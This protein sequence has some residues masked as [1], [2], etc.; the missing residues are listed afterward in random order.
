MTSESTSGE[1][2]VLEF[3]EIRLDLQDEQ[4]WRG[5]RA[6]QLRP[7]TWQVLRHLVEQ[8]GKLVTTSQLL[9]A[10]WSDVDVSQGTLTQSIAELRRALED[11]AGQ[12]RFIQTVHRRGYRFIAAFRSSPSPEAPHGP[13][14]PCL[15]PS[16][17][18]GKKERDEG[19][20]PGREPEL[21]RLNLLMNEA[22]AGKRQIVFVSGEAGIGKTC[23]IRTFLKGLTHRKTEEPVWIT[24]GRCVEF[25]GEGETFLPVLEALEHLAQIVEPKRFRR[26]VRSRAPNWLAQIPWLAEPDEEQET[27][28]SVHFAT[29]KR[30]LRE[31]CVAVEALTAEGTL[32]LWIEDLHWSDYATVDLIAALASRTEPC[33]LLL[34]ATYRPVEAAMNSHPIAPL[35]RNLVQQQAGVEL[36]LRPLNK[37][38]IQSYLDRQFAPGFEPSLVDVIYDLT[39]GNPLFMVTLVNHLFDKGLLKQTDEQSPWTLIFPIEQL[40]DSPPESLGALIE[41]QLNRMDTESLSALEAGSVEGV[42][43]GAQAA[44]AAAGK[45]VE[46]VETTLGMLAG[47]GQFLKAVG[48]ERWPDGSVG[49]G[50]RFL[51]AA[52]S[53]ILYQR[54]TAARRQ[55]AHLRIAERL[56]EGFQ[57]QPDLPAAKLA[58]HFEKGGDPERAVHYLVRAA[59]GARAR[60]GDRETLKYFN[61]TFDQLA[62][63]PDTDERARLELDLRMKLARELNSAAGFSSAQQGL[64]LARALELCDRFGDGSTLGYIQSYQARSQITASDFEAVWSLRDQRLELAESLGDPVLLAAT[65]KE[66][67]EV[68]MQRADF[69]CARQEFE[70]CLEAVEGAEPPKHH[71]MHGHDSAVMSLGL[72]GWTAWEQGLPDEAQRKAEACLARADFVAYPFDRLLA[73]ILALAVAVLRRDVDVATPLAGA[74]ED[75]A[76]EY[77]FTLPQAVIPAALGWVMARNGNTAAAAEQMREGIAVSRSAGTVRFLSF[78]LVTLAQTELEHGGA[79]EGFEA[80]GEAL[81]H[82]EKTGDRIHEAEIHRLRGELLRLDGGD[83][84][85]GACF[86]QALEVARSQGARSLELRA[87]TSLSRFWRDESREDEARSLLAPVYDG[88]TEGFDTQDLRDAKA[89]LDSL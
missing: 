22:R 2:T 26:I 35:K 86:E 79:E 13:G 51:H 27:P 44:A 1:P 82:V 10:V 85:A 81:T 80:L 36:P 46:A 70:R 11:D 21:E 65:H 34:L 71:A 29:P 9:D 45:D 41:L 56:E 84:H 52:F 18:L 16:P 30:L 69:E 15:P 17:F 68:A 77:G 48:A 50:F 12:P 40:R 6:V 78:L 60:L 3:N 4:V 87:A 25:V 28:S 49:E 72:A 23:L 89:L 38:A 32:V 67:G 24:G 14:V 62:T 63:L 61:R 7:K 5:N 53:H 83:E 37:T 8:A 54:Q 57:D 39:E 19:W 73:N 66:F 47:R 75:L 59:T 43:F 58:L 42:T 76:E 31:F 64:S 74:Y 33:R 55:R 88:F 20:L